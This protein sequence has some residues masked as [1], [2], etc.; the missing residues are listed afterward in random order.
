MNRE[1][2]HQTAIVMFDG[3]SSADNEFIK[4]WFKNSRFSTN[5]T[6]DIFQAIEE[7]SDFTVSARP[8][9]VLL[10]VDSI[11]KDYKTVRE[12]TN[13]LSENGKFP[14]FA[15]SDAGK[16]VNDRECFEGNLKKVEARL[17]RIIPKVF[18]TA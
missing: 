3:K 2:I 5:E 9:V 12:M 10:E 7:I 18:P 4:N 13:Y 14:I 16:I 15:L 6:T 8:D 1:I 17:E 11:E